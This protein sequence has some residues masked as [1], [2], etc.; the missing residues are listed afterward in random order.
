MKFEE[1]WLIWPI[2]KTLSRE[3]FDTPTKI[4]ER[5][6][7]LANKWKDILGCAQTGSG[8]TLAFV[9][10]ILQEL[11]SAR[12]AKD[13]PDGPIKRKIE[14]L[15]IAPTRELAVQ[16]WEACKPFCSDTNMKHTVIFGGVNDFHQIKAVEK[17]VD[18][19]IA[20]PGRLE[21]LISQW[22]I[23]LS[24][25]KLLVLDEADRML[26]LGFLSD[27]QKIIKRVPDNKQTLFFSA[28]M[29]KAIADL[30]A[31]LLK[32]PEKITIKSKKPT[33]ENI[34]Q[35]VYHVKTSHRRQLLQMLVKRKEYQSIIVFVKK[36]DD[37]AYVTEYVK[38]S[39][40]KVEY[41]NKDR[42]QNGRQKALNAL[43]NGDVKVLV[44]T[45]LASRGIDIED[46]SCVINWNV[47]NEA[48]TYIH[49]VGRTARAGKTGTAIT[50]C[51]EHERED[52]RKVEKL[53]WNKIPVSDDTSYLGEVVSKSKILWY[54]N[55]EENGK[56]KY[57]D[58]RRKGIKSKK[59][60]S[61]E[62][63]YGKAGKVEVKR[64]KKK[65]TYVKRKK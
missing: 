6:I 1:L 11:Y 32:S 21:D 64:K 25:V 56:E 46:L 49:R 30:A 5:V 16:I 26:D 13:L 39:G 53:I 55:F 44:G 31:G 45:D 8:K 61:P 34:E 27:M 48:E 12:I 57:S 52:L 2:L 29:P 47:P 51:I 4:Q 23:K 9:L 35:S 58:I 63:K 10:P 24:Y 43:K 38:A 28:T 41:I 62:K 40:I 18:I 33:L 54:K 59:N 36:K 14:A 65:S 60:N 42:N 20:T 15:I 37:V 19:V 3:G 17:W 22:K 50:M 7:P